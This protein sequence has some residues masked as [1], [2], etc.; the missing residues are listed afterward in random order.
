MTN[1]KRLLSWLHLRAIVSW[2]HV[3]VISPNRF[4]ILNWMF[5]CL[6][7]PSN[8]SLFTLKEGLQFR[9][10]LKSTIGR[11]LFLN[12]GFEDV[13]LGFVSQTLNEGDIFFD[14]GAN[15]G[16]FTVIASQ[17][18]GSSG[19]V[20][21]FEP[22]ERELKLLRENILLNNLCNVTV[23]SSAVSNCNG[24]TQF[25]VSNDGALN[26]ILE[27]DHPY[28][29]MKEKREVSVMTLDSFIAEQ[30]ISKIDFIKIDVEG[31][32]KLV[33]EGAISSLK[34]L[35]PVI[36]FEAHAMTSA[37][38]GYLPNDLFI[39]LKS[40]NFSINCINRDHSLD[41]IQDAST[42]EVYNFVALSDPSILHFDSVEN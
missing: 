41:Q 16:L 35:K 19:H 17:K 42:L 4:K 28:Q 25:V 7:N 27:N 21:A 24:K 40:L 34:R 14:V 9:Y 6:L 1:F 2:L 22:G 31:A 15:G 26:S 39:L 11:S 32:E 3:L 37:A 12:G 18:V 29:V 23:V 13:E 5:K 33:L 38:F 20:Y 8:I 36:L 10:P 30:K